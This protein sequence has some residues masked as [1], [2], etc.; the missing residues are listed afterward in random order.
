MASCEVLKGESTQRVISN[1]NVF[2]E[3]ELI[4]KTEDKNYFKILPIACRNK[5]ERG[6]HQHMTG[7]LEITFEVICP[8]WYLQGFMSV[9][10]H[11][12][13]LQLSQSVY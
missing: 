11:R 12:A 8:A 10:C 13:Y 2:T 6:N 5:F 9:D 1:R 4:L 3:Q 7:F